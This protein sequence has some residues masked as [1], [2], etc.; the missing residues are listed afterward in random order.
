MS[1]SSPVRRY[2]ITVEAVAQYAPE[3]SAPDENRYVFAYQIT[4]TNSGDCP[5]KLV[6][7][8]WTIRDADGCVDEVQGDGVIGEQ[9]MLAPG[10]S[11]EYASG[12]ALTTPFG[13]MHGSYRMRAEDGTEF[14][15]DIP[16][17]FLVGPRVLH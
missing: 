14:E 16:E 4:I 5:A 9:P 6:R 12:C 3:H 7:R 11:F 15:A 8:H 1:E 13:S 10:Q 2:Q 17:F